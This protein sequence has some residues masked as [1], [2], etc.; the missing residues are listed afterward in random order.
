VNAYKIDAIAIGNG[1]AG[2]ETE[3]FIRHIPR[4]GSY[5]SV[6]NE[7]GASITRVLILPLKF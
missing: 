6:V 3:N 1:T 7:A 2:R 5:R 4:N